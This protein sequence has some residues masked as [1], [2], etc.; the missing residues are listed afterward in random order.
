M[1]EKGGE[2]QHLHLA[3]IIMV[4]LEKLKSVAFKA[5]PSGRDFE[6]LN[7]E[8]HFIQADTGGS[9]SRTYSLG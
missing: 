9:C 4:H 5:G 3:R 6:K 8:R 7:G 1:E 2:A